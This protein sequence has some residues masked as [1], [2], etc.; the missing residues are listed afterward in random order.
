MLVVAALATVAVLCFRT[1]AKEAVYPLERFGAILRRKV[2]ANPELD[3]LRRENGELRLAMREMEETA[4][5]NVRLRESLGYGERHKAEYVAAEILSRR[6]PAA[7]SGEKIRIGKGSLDGIKTGAVAVSPE[8]LVGL[9]IEVSPHTA[10][11]ATVLDKSSRVSVFAETSGG[12]KLHGILAG[13]GE[14]I[15]HLRYLNGDGDKLAPHSRVFSS[16]L[17]GVFPPNIEIGNV[18]SRDGDVLPAVDFS[19]LEDVFVSR[20]R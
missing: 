10:T 12:G 11:V 6:G 1:F 18:V 16:G 20:E 2:F 17:G 15:L 3:R 4:A 13:C 5:E 9:V 8:G 19:A 7:G 14:G